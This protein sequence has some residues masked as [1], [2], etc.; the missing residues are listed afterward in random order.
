[1]AKEPRIQKHHISYEPEI[2]VKIFQGEH[3]IITELNRHTKNISNNFLNL[4]Q[5]WIDEHR[6]LGKEI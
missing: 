3:L 6:Y 2:V 1:M 5:K 4:L